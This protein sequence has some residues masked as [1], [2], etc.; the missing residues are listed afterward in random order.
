M[1]HTDHSSTSTADIAQYYDANT[2]K[3]LRYGGSGDTNAIHRAIWAP[4]VSN[5]NDAFEYLN[6]L[7]ANSLLPITTN[8]TVAAKCLDLGCG[9]GGT[10]MHLAEQLNI[11]VTGVTIS[12]TQCDIASALAEQR[13][14]S[15]KTHF[16]TADFELLPNLQTF[17]SAYA[18]ESFAHAQ[19]AQA[20]MKMVANQLRTG[21][22]FIMCDDFSQKQ[23]SPEA[24]RWIA[25]FKRGW[26]LHTV[27][28]VDQVCELAST[29]GLRLIAQHDLSSY[30]RQFPAAFLWPLSQLTRIPLPWAYWENLAGGTALQR[31]VK[32]GWTE[33]HALIWEK[34]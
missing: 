24:L 6:E 10:A 13:Q 30:L 22:R 9:V 33:Y 11:S 5:S 18:V 28:D 8:N 29:A 14:L 4:Q 19:D 16:I 15:D 34:A 12:K 31:C 20:F 27:L 32:Q 3:F 2:R 26:H 7:I 1:K 21:G 17:D 25:R 23:A